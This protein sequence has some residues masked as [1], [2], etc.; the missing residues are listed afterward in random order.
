MEISASTIHSFYN[1]EL[2]KI[3]RQETINNLSDAME[4][5]HL[6]KVCGLGYTSPYM[7][8]L[9]ESHPQ[10]IFQEMFPDFLGAQQAIHLSSALFKVCLFSV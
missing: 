1:S 2:G 10:C 5:H 4:G 7:A 3:V 6:S 9:K 8:F